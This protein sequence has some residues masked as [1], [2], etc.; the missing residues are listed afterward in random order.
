M[1][2]NAVAEEADPKTCYLCGKAAP[3]ASLINC[4]CCFLNFNVWGTKKYARSDACGILSLNNWI[5][6][7]VGRDSD[8]VECSFCNDYRNQAF[9]CYACDN[10]GDV[11]CLQCLRKNTFISEGVCNACHSRRTI[12]P[13][14]P[15]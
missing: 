10:C 4:I 6:I 14:M 2:R 13:M 3:R 11:V 9:M 15:R 12:T 5:D 1:P 7:T 8:L